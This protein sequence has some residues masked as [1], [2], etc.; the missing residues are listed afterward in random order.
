MLKGEK[1]NSRHLG[2]E[3][4]QLPSSRQ[5]IFNEYSSE[6]LLQPGSAPPQ[7]GGLQESLSMEILKCGN[8]HSQGEQIHLFHTPKS[9]S[10]HPPKARG[11]RQD[12][13]ALRFGAHPLL[14]SLWTQR[15][16]AWSS[17]RQGWL[18]KIFTESAFPMEWVHCCDPSSSP[19]R[20]G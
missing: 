11:L 9:A 7:R 5:W 1:G 18:A 6:Q 2:Q 13:A 17:S 8:T 16:L 3:N 10:K 19:G 4:T 15:G 14:T 12:Q 20:R